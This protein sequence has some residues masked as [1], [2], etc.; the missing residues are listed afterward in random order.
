MRKVIMPVVGA[1]ALFAGYWSL[2]RDMPTGVDPIVSG[3]IQKKMSSGSA[4]NF[5]LSNIEAASTCTIS[6]G[7]SLTYR[8]MRLTVSAE[9]EN[10]WQGLSH[11]ATWTETGDGSVVIAGVSGDDILTLMQ[12]DGSAYEVLDPPNAMITI[13]A[14]N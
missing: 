2:D 11:A 9:C 6:R 1:M 3:S 10:V 14:T 7:D 4:K 13:N 5:S 8:S 12:G